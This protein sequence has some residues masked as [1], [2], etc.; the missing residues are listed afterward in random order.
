MDADEL[1]AY[2]TFALT[3][4]L[5][6]AS[7]ALA[8]S[9]MRRG[10]SEKTAANRYSLAAFASGCIAGFP[11]F[12]GILSLCGISGARVNVGHGE[13]LIAAPLCNAVLGLVLAGV[14]RVILLWEPLSQDGQ[15]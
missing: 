7:F 2:I 10:V 8:F 5:A 14:G 3:I 1:I 12:F 6:I 15:R 13:I 4:I 11:C 9:A